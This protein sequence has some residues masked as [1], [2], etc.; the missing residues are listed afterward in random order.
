MAQV[1][2]FKVTGL[3]EALNTLKSLPAEVVSKRGGPVKTAVRKASLVILREM[4]LN[5]AA[6]TGHVDADGQL[7]QSTEVL[8]R[9]LR[10]RRGK[11]PP[12]ENGERYV[13]GPR[14]V[15]YTDRKGAVVTTLMTGY[16]LEFGTEDQPAEPW[17]RPVSSKAGEALQVGADELNKAIDRVVRKLQ[18]AK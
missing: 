10:T 16:W 18:K 17:S 15:R 1:I 2:A 6:R 9:S 3:D 8:L 12:G 5:V 14:R 11:P 4:A 13:V 7:E